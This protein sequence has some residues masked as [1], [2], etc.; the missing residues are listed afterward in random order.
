M[1]AGW[2]RHAYNKMKTIKHL[3][4]Y[5]KLENTIHA[6]FYGCLDRPT[7]RYLLY[8][9]SKTLAFRNYCLRRDLKAFQNEMFKVFM[10]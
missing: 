10:K 8:K 1:A 6:S 7:K 3:K 4:D 9:L 2:S 5:L